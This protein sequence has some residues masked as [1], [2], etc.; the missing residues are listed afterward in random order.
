VNTINEDDLKDHSYWLRWS[1]NAGLATDAVKNTLYSYGY[2]AHKD[3]KAA[4][5][6]IDISIKVVT[7]KLYFPKKVYVAHHKYHR[8][9]QSG[10]IIDL[11]RAKRLLKR[12]GNLEINNVLKD[13][14]SKLC[15]P[16]WTTVLQIGLEE[17]FVENGGEEKA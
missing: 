1:I 12:Y 6:A 2:L 13:F 5:V 10:G 7:Y 11:W 16:E 17:D 14:V 4:E 8:L 15:G 9:M 3:V